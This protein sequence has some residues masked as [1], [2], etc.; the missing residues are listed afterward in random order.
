MGAA[1]GM[2]DFSELGGSPSRHASSAKRADE[3]ERILQMRLPP[4][5]NPKFA[6]AWL[7]ALGDRPI[8]AMRWY[9]D[10]STD[11]LQLVSQV[12]E[13]YINWIPVYSGFK[14]EFC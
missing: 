10:K 11:T 1:R 12:P 8:G 9:E 4:P 13:K 14:K 7:V 5:T 3:R 6:P 2:E